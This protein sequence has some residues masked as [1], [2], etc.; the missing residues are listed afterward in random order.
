MKM[1]KLVKVAVSL[2][3][4]AVAT[5]EAFGNPQRDQTG[6][7]YVYVWVTGS[8]IPQKVKITPIGTNT[9]SAMSVW[10]R[11]QINQAFRV[12]GGGILAQDPSVRVISQRLAGR[13]AN[14]SS[15]RFKDEIKPMDKTSEAIL[16]L[17]PVTFRYKKEIDRKGIPQFGLVAEDVEKVNPDLVTR[18]RDGKLYTVR[19]DAVNAMLLN[20]FLKEHQTVQEQGAAIAEFK[21]EIANLTATVKE[22]AAQIQKVSA[23]V[24][25]S[26]GAQQ[27]LVSN[28]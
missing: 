6:D 27:T 16:A 8:R 22:Q 5:T 26:R 15:A 20:E 3:I 18:D 19:Y 21:K 12:T 4:L 13:G 10:D 7:R 28:P 17:K 11:H 1:S 24:E 25:A 14:A 9:V 23:Q 2:L